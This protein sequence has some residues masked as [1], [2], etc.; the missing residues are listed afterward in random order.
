MYIS[1]NTSNLDRN[2]ICFPSFYFSEKSITQQG[3]EQKNNITTRDVVLQV[4]FIEM[5]LPL[6]ISRP[7]LIMARGNNRNGI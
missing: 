3:F 2:Y 5:Y 4:F 1:D 6:P 7:T